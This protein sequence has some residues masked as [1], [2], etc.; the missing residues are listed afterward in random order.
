MLLVESFF[1]YLHQQSLQDLTNFVMKSLIQKAQQ[2]ET[3][4]RME[5]DGFSAANS[6]FSL[7]EIICNSDRLVMV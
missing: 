6:R 3:V 2:K 4:A 1:F 7:V 5:T